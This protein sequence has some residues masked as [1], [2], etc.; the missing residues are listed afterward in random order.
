MYCVEEVG[1]FFGQKRL[2][3]FW[4]KTIKNKLSTIINSL[5]QILS[6]I[7]QIFHAGDI[8]ITKYIPCG[9]GF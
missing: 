6:N 2:K 1:L 3:N 9:C 5:K 4:S 7:V 8:M